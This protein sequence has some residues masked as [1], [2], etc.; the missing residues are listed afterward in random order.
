MG[1]ELGLVGKPRYRSDCSEEER[2]ERWL[3]RKSSFTVKFEE[4][5]S[6]S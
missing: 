4:S 6:K 5:F 3:S 1:K 2:E